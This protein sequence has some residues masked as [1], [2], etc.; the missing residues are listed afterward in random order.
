[1]EGRMSAPCGPSE[2]FWW[3]LSLHLCAGRATPPGSAGGGGGGELCSEVAPGFWLLTQPRVGG[4]L[5][6]FHHPEPG[7]LPSVKR[8]SGLC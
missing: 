7:P 4:W 5:W 2:V 1:M 8:L 3:P 6:T